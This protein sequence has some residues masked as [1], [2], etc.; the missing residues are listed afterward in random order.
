MIDHNKSHFEN[1]SDRGLGKWLNLLRWFCP[2]QLYEEI[3]GDLIQK[4]RRNTSMLG[5]RGAKRKFVLSTLSFF[6]PGIILRNQRFRYRGQFKNVSKFLTFPRNICFKQVNNLTGWVIFVIALLTYTLTMEETGSLWDCGEFI[7][8][9]YKLQVPHPPG[10]PL[11]LLVGRIFSFL[12]M[13]DVSKIAYAINLISVLASALTILFL[14]WSIVLFGRKMIDIDDDAQITNEKKL[15]LVSAGAVGSL[16][17]A[18]SDSFWFSAVEAEVYALSSFFTA[19]VIWCILRW[20]QIENRSQ[21]NRWLLLIAYSVGLSIGVHLLSLLTLP[22]LALIYYFKRFKTSFWGVI[23]TLVIG[24]GLILLIDGLIIPGLPAIAG[25]FEIFFVNSIGL[26]FGSG[27]LVFSVLL[28]GALV[29]GIYITHKRNYPAMNTFLLSAAFVIVGY[30]S[31]AIVVIRSNFDPPINED[32]PKDVMSFVR[33]LKREQYGSRPLLYGPYFTSNPIGYQYGDKIYVKGKDK[34]EESGRKLSYAYDEEGETIFPRAWDSDNKEAYKSIMELPEGQRPDFLQNLGFLL[35]HQ[36]GTMYLRYFMW[37]FAGRESDQQGAD[38]LK[39]SAWFQQIP[40][41]LSA[42]KGRNNFFMIP[43]VLGIIGMLYQFRKDRS[44]FYVIAILFFMLGMGI[45]VYLNSPPVEPRER[46][47]IYVGSYYAFAIWIGLSVIALANALSRLSQNRRIAFASATLIGLV[48]PIL[49][50]LN[51]WNDHDRSNRFFTVDSATN[52]LTSCATNGVLFTG[53]DNDTFPLWYAQEAEG[54]RTDLRVLV[55]SYCNTDWYIDQTRRKVY[56]S[57]PFKYTLNQSNY[58]QRGFNDYLPY[59]DAKIK[60]IDA[61]EFLNLLK[62]DNPLLQSEGRNIIPSRII[63]VPVDKK[64][65]L[66]SKIIPNE[67]RDLVVD[68]ME[69]NLLKDGL[70]KKDLVFLDLLVA[71]NW[72]RPIYL[73]YTSLSQLNLDLSPYLVQEGNVYRVLPVKNPNNDGS[74]LVDTERS[75]DLI[76][77]KFRYRRLDDPA[78][79]YNDDYKIQVMTHRSNLNALA[80]ALID[81]GDSQKAKNVLLFSLEKMPDEAVPYDPSAPDTVNLLFK[82]G[83]R[84]KALEMAQVIGKR[85]DDLAYYLITRN[86]ILTMELRKCFFLLDAMQRTLFDNGERDL[87]QIYETRYTELAY[88]FQSRMQKKHTR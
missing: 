20:D 29:Y 39:P 86:G 41:A 50:A 85:A 6:R 45:V 53:G 65:V 14:F 60:S 83:Q 58:R 59:V 77:N 68:K 78:V 51:G 1:Q 8:A 61:R 3:E 38:W 22:G 82:V 21:S 9:A 69:L 35:E 10:A 44:R 25:N 28:I 48:A 26:F 64:T 17:Y 57:T 54:C 47:Y 23:L 55:L 15:F 67:F 63:T 32:A 24:F 70:E 33:Y 46:D 74:Y 16:A 42:N 18:F 87:A 11:Y 80:Q 19:F 43:F 66:A 62:E 7:A 37:N 88:D 79:Y 56:Q 49:M 75:Y 71:N 81:K 40:A 4:F 34:Y 2:E 27:T 5:E 30:G 52:S 36:I 73:N 13:G 31:Y 12:S 76:L 72:Q 84:K